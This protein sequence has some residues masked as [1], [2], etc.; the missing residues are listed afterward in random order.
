M[1]S[2]PT[3]ILWRDPSQ[4]RDPHGEGTHCQAK[5]A[6]WPVRRSADSDYLRSYRITSRSRQAPR[7]VT[8]T[9]G[10]K[11]N[12]GQHARARLQKASRKLASFPTYRRWGQEGRSVGGRE[13]ADDATAPGAQKFSDRMAQ[14]AVESLGSKK[15]CRRFSWR[16]ESTGNE[17]HIAFPRTH[18]TAA[19][20]TRIGGSS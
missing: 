9:Q 11:K 4:L 6:R 2:A 1:T 10:S 17:C 14:V 20:S 3:M 12:G 8:D 13:D 15:C 7:A 16:V 19:R 18:R 5:E